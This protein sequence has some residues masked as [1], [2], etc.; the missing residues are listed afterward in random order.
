MTRPTRR[1][2]NPGLF[3]GGVPGLGKWTL[4]ALLITLPWGTGCR[5]DPSGLPA[6]STDGALFDGALSDGTL[7]DGTQPDAS[8]TCG[9]GRIDQGEACDGDQLDGR[10]CESLG[11][12]GG[13]LACTS[14]CLFDFRGCEGTPVC[15]NGTRDPGEDCD[16]SDFGSATCLSVAGHSSGALL[17]TATCTIDSTLCH[18][19]GNGA[20]EGSE[21]CDQTVGGE[22]CTSRGHTGGTLACGDDCRFDEEGCHTCGDGLCNVAAGE[23]WETC[24]ADCGW[25]QLSAGDNHTCG[26]RKDGTAYCWGKNDKGQLGLDNTTD[27]LTPTRILVGGRV[28]HISAGD[29]FTCAVLVD[30]TVACFGLNDKGQI[31]DGTTT[32][33]LAPTPV[34][35]LTGVRQVSAGGK[36]ACALNSLGQLFCWGLNDKG[37]LG[38]GTTNDSGTA[39]AV[40]TDTGLGAV[41]SVS[42]GGK[43]TCAL[44]QDFSAWCWG[45]GTKGKLGNDG[46]G[47]QSRPST[48]STLTGLTAGRHISAGAA[49]TCA[50]G[51]DLSAWCWGDKADGRLGDG[52]NSDQSEPSLVAQGTGIGSVIS[53]AAAAA[54]SC[55]LRSDGAVFC[56]GKNDKGAVGDG[57]YTSPRALP[58][59]V[60]SATGL[61]P[62]SGVQAG[63]AHSL[64]WNDAGEGWAWGLGSSGQLGDGFT[65]DRNQP[66]QILP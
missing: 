36:H 3:H 10:T 62:A 14:N 50:V 12:T 63:G 42:A 56:W 25:G 24:P 57:S 65:L 58:T 27:R 7:P 15:G 5:F 19:C 54:H 20:V 39:S 22:T 61:V 6:P 9:N 37:Q 41:R 45:E 64:G 23:R 2:S 49:H 21:E 8:P 55:A 40:S 59:A 16:G 44:A 17:C 34:V 47:N 60:L 1:S 26:L 4:A 33:R 31:G 35:G 43:H 66:T 11:Y 32:D 48:V 46:T 51:Q 30:G 38:I 52:T 13:T 29:S 28:M 53:I 18:T